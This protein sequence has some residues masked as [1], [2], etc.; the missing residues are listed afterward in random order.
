MKK[1]KYQFSIF[2]SQL[3]TFI[4]KE[5]KH[6]FR[7]KKTLLMLFGMP[8]AQIILFGFALTNEIKDS[9]VGVL[10]F[11][12]D[13]VSRQ[14]IEK[15]DESNYFNVAEDLK[16]IK[17]VD[18]AFKQNKIRAAV[19]FPPGF[20][21]E[22]LHGGHSQIQLIADAS[23][24]NAATSITNYLS[25][26]ITEYQSQQT[27]VAAAPMQIMAEVHMLY[28]PELKG[29]PNFVPGVIALVLMLVCT[30]MSSVSIVKEKELGTMEILLVSPFKPIYIIISKLMPFLIISLFNLAIILVLS[31]TLLDLE[32]KG[33]IFLLFFASMLF[34]ITSL[35]IGLL[36]STTA[37]TQQNAMMISLMGMMLPTMLLTGFMFPIENMPIVLR[38]LSN[39]VPSRWFFIIIKNVM[40]KGLGIASIWKELLILTAMCVGLLTL[41]IKKFKIRL[42]E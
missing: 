19:V 13:I 9:K 32:I 16:S 38:G 15:I 26:I 12:K 36:I 7:D 21:D 28:N 30:M 22:L 39:I 2:N 33:N 41:S 18:A 20:A 34:I 17:D 4:K 6:V 42:Q 8:T 5:F 40:L 24:P 11:S 3:I 37:K 29:A 31:V 14:I 27:T 10:D 1:H 35:A 25:N 23:D